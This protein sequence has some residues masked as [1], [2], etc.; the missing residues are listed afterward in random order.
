MVKRQG[1]LSDRLK[2]PTMMATRAV[3][4]KRF[5]MESR[6]IS[7]M[8]RKAELRKFVINLQ[9]DSISSDLGDDARCSDGKRLPV[10]LD[11]A[12][13]R[14]WEKFQGPPIDEAVIG[15]GIEGL[16][17]SAHREM[18]GLEDIEPVDFLVVR[19]CDCPADPLVLGDDLIEAFPIH[20]A[21]F[22]GIVE[23]RASEA[24]R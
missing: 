3:Y 11:D 8:F 9:H 10:S 14:Q 2:R 6:A 24:L 12:I 4:P 15:P 16:C 17:C 21:D 18:S 5:K 7:L 23:P 20:G 1:E 13:V 19:G 22:L